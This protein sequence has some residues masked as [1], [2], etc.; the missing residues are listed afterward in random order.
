MQ[1]VGTFRACPRD[2]GSRQRQA[3]KPTRGKSEEITNTLKKTGDAHVQ[4]IQACK[5]TGIQASN[6]SKQTYMHEKGD[7]DKGMERLFNTARPQTAL[8]RVCPEVLGHCMWCHVSVRCS[9]A[10]SPPETHVQASCLK[11][12]S[13]PIQT[14]KQGAKTSNSMQNKSLETHRRHTHTQVASEYPCIG[15]I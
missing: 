6:A 7:E 9:V 1:Q 11:Q 4:A 3:R 12:Q 14:T 13:R 5:H 15:P 2:S 10:L 8:A